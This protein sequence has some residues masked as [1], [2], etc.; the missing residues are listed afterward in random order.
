MPSQGFQ[1]TSKIFR[2]ASMT[3][4]AVSEKNSLYKLK[5][6]YILKIFSV[7]KYHYA[8][9]NDTSVVTKS[10]VRRAAIF[11]KPNEGNLKC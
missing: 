5:L 2:A 10:Q 7:A 9:L 4:F 6:F 3:L 8:M 1:N 11:P